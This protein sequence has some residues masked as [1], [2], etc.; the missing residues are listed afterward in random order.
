[1]ADTVAQSVERGGGEEEGVPETERRAGDCQEEHCPLL[2]P[3][4]TGNMH[5]E[6]PIIIVYHVTLLVRLG[7]PPCPCIL[8]SCASQTPTC[9]SKMFHIIL[10][11]LNLMTPFNVQF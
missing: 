10:Q 11:R 3:G 7:K 2:R 6:N 9:L 5:T 8:Q 4:R 1:M